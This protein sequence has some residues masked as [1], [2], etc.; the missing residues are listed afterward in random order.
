MNTTFTT[1]LFIASPIFINKTT[2]GLHQLAKYDFKKYK[3]SFVRL[4]IFFLTLGLGV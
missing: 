4:F 2:Q 3:D 1:Y